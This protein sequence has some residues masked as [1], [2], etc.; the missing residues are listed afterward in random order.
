MCL[1]SGLWSIWAWR[2]T[3]RP[4]SQYLVYKIWSSN[5]LHYTLH[6]YPLLRSLFCIPGLQDCTSLVD[7]QTE[8]SGTTLQA[9]RIQPIEGRNGH[10]SFQIPDAVYR[11]LRPP[12]NHF[13]LF[14]TGDVKHMSSFLNMSILLIKS[15]NGLCVFVNSRIVPL[16]THPGRFNAPSRSIRRKWDQIRA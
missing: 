2:S 11:S 14:E 16:W 6:C 8:K 4:I 10:L 9:E 15:F 5:C 1:S 7:H 12:H 3:L 13:L